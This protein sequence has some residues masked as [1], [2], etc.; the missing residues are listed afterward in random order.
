MMYETH[1]TG[2][3]RPSWEREMDLQLFRHER[4]RYWAGTL[5]QHRQSNPLYRRMRIG[6]AQRELS[7]SNCERFLAPAYG[8]VSHAEW[9]RRCCN[10]ALPT[11]AH[12]WYADDDGLW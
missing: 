2:L 6:A 8:C 4:L 3:S 10:T 12:V 1:W 5:N 7:R 9:V 11:G